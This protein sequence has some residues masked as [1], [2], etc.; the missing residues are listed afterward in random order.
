MLLNALK[1]LAGIDDSVHLISPSVIEPISALKVK[2]MG[3]HNPRLHMDEVLIA[4]AI[5]ATA[6]PN[7]R[8]A[9]D[10]LASL[11]HCEAH[12]TVILSHVDENVFNKLG[13]NLTSEAKYQ[14]KKLYHQ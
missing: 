12:S 6:D 8:K 7:A 10:A 9:M 14:T 4:L 2:H 3:N 11:K 13:M 1:T 5:S